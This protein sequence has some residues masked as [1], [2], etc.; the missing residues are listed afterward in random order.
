MSTKKPV[1]LFYYLK[2]YAKL[3]MPAAIFKLRRN[4]IISSAQKR[5]DYDYIINRVNY[6]NK[7]TIPTSLPIE[8][9]KKREKTFFNFLGKIKEYTIKT[10]HSAYFFDLNDVMLFFD[11]N[12]RICYQPGD[13][14]HTPSIPAFV[15]S[16]LISDNNNNSVV[17]KLDKHR[18]FM[19]INDPVNLTDK[20]NKA[21]F[22]GKIRYSRQRE[23]FMQMYFGSDI[24]N[25]G[26]VENSPDYPQ[27]WI[28]PK[29][30]LR[31][32]LDYKFIIALEGNDVASNLKWVMSSNSIA[33]MPRPTCETWFMEGT[34]IPDYHYISIN[35]DMSDLEE[36]L[37]YYINNP[38]KA[39]E[40]INH[41]H[42]YIAQFQDSKREEIIQIMVADKYFKYTEQ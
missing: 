23:R 37:N 3:L 22:R 34:L 20:K 13:V 6:Y 1:K 32:H 31:E 4:R 33:V 2:G 35:D 21:I 26:I 14:Y 8:D 24:C 39:Q 10:F 11:K 40:I 12:K 5:D 18:H 7:L 30:T 28:T 36:K 27:E 25:C 19:F 9:V 17:L 16:R 38:D 41:A 42:E 29:I 15:K